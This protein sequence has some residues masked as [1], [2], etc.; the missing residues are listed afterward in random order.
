[1]KKYV[2]IDIGTNKICI[3][4]NE[5]NDNIRIIQNSFGED[6]EP[7]LLSIIK[8]DVIAGENVYLNKDSN[9]YNTISEIK[10]LISLNFLKDDNY[11]EEYKK[12]LSYKIEKT[13][14]GHIIIKIGEKTYSIE[15]ILSY[16]IKNIVENCQNQDIFPKKYVFTIPSCFGIFERQLIKKAALLADI[17]KQ[18]ITMITET[19]AAALAYELYINKERFETNYDYNIIKL[20]YGKITAGN[21]NLT[22]APILKFDKKLLVVDLG[23]GSFNL[24]ILHITEESKKKLNF[25]VKANLGNPFFGGVDFDNKLVEYC[26]NDFCKINEINEED[27]YNDKKAI[28]MLKLRCEMAKIILS[29][30]QRVIIHVQNFFHDNDLCVQIDRSIFDKI[31]K[32]YYEEIRNKV[33]KIL[34]MAEMKTEN[35]K[36][37]LVIGGNSKIPKIIDILTDIFGQKKI[38]DFIDTDKIVAIGSALYGLK[39]GKNI[40]KFDLNENVISSLGVAVANPDIK[41]Y[42]KYGD[43]MFKFLRKNW[44]VRAWT[45]SF[46]IKL[47]NKNKNMININIYEGESNFVK[48][49][50]NIGT[51]TLSNFDKFLIDSYIHLNITF[52]LDPYYILKVSV[53]IQESNFKKEIIIGDLDESRLSGLKCKLHKVDLNND[54]IA[55]KNDLREYSYDQLK[56]ESRNKTLKNCCKCSEEIIKQYQNIYDNR[57]E[58]G[59][60]KIYEYTTELFSYYKER[61]KI[62]NKEVNDNEQII[63]EIKNRMRYYINIEGYNE[64][65]IKIFKEV[66]I[67]DKNLYYL[68][69]LNY[70]ELIIEV[71]I[72]ILKSEKNAKQYYFKIFYEKSKRVI[73]EY[74]N[75]MRDIVREELIIRIEILQNINELTTIFISDSNENI[76]GFSNLQNIEN[77]V[78]KLIK[79]NNYSSL[80][81]IL[82]LID[83][84][85]KL[86]K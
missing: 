37:V 39:I 78:I 15:E 33:N 57:N 38:I 63:K 6:L 83:D 17:D 66:F 86:Q 62:K 61:L 40:K 56:D 48:Y 54:F 59:I 77:K 10:R 5:D 7:P 20:D 30:E 67:A 74:S 28:K 14:D 58:K 3:G 2:G 9:V 52:N 43:K 81:D 31:C 32:D 36:Q 72:N 65:L 41:S 44:Q 21:E 69:I 23:A 8:N 76:N 71:N 4:L 79:E 64:I 19:S 26:I 42:L 29:K 55:I 18:K 34:K 73:E 1:M 16:L 49:N 11:F 12:F 22:S 53:E 13:F 51:I 25:K 70:I 60:I 80:N 24:T 84:I 50:K 47:D 45:N 68:I 35:I 82:K 27:I 75:Q 85:K 46:Q